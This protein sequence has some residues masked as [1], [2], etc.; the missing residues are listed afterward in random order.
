[1]SSGGNLLTSALSTLVALVFVLGLAWGFVRLLRHFQDRRVP[2][3]QGPMPRV[4]HS[5]SLG[6]RERLVSVDYAGKRLL[7]GVTAASIQLL[8]SQPAAE[9]PEP[10]SVE[11][12]R[13][14]PDMH[15]DATPV[16][17]PD[18]RT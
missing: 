13:L 10:G 18:M 14:D 12:M 2:G 9:A 16:R 1:M 11:A 6:P 5:L 3:S 17:A 8:D 7:L 4:V 15:D